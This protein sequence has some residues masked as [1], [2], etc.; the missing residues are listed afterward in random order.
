GGG[1]QTVWVLGDNKMP[2]PV[3]VKLGITDGNFSEVIE[4]D[5]R[6]QQEVIVGITSKD[7]PAG[8]GR[9][10]PAGQRGPRLF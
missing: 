1:G 6:E 3:A 10:Q 8:S 9:P 4:G 5:L 7:A 2:R